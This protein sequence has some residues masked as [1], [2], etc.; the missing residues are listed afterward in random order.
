LRD[1]I[2]KN[3]STINFSGLPTCFRWYSGGLGLLDE[4]SL[5][6]EWDQCFFSEKDAKKGRKELQKI[7]DRYNFDWPKNAPAWIYES[8]AVL[9]Q[10]YH[11]L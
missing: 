9:E 10:M 8:Q 2:K 11:K 3:R 5:P 6:Y 7:F 4:D 1:N